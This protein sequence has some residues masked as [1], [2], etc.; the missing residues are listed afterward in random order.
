MKHLFIILS[1]LS[2]FICCSG[3]DPV[4]SQDEALLMDDVRGL[5]SYHNGEA[6]SRNLDRLIKLLQVNE[7][8]KAF[9]DSLEN[10]PLCSA[11]VYANSNYSYEEFSKC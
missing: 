7:V 9:L 6:V 1:F 5:E 2:L 10:S 8:N 11:F 3:Q 4:H